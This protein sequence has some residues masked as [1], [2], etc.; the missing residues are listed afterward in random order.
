MACGWRIVGVSIIVDGWGCV[1]A[2]NFLQ[3]HLKTGG[4]KIAMVFGKMHFFN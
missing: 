2:G 4:A 3:K 1:C